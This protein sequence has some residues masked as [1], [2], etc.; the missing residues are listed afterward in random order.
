MT[1]N[2]LSRALK[3]IFPTILSSGFDGPW[4]FSPTTLT[5]DYFR[6]LLDEKWV[7]KK[8]E[9]PK[10]FV[11][12]DTKGLMM[13]PADMALVQDK[14]FRTY[15]EKYAKDND[16]FFN[17]FRNVLVKLFELGVLNGTA[18]VS[19]VENKVTVSAFCR[20]RLAV[21]MCAMHMAETV[22]AVCSLA[23]FL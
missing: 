16:A 14:K 12:K 17:D 9:G 23:W 18:K 10:Q 3:L 5:N 21:V 8:W 19:D 20:R 6:L 13:L 1:A 11:D 2:R 4:T 15:V 22:S 7:W